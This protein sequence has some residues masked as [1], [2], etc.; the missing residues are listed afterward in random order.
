M[1]VDFDKV[2]DLNRKVWEIADSIDI[3]FGNKQELCGALNQPPHLKCEE[4]AEDLPRPIE[5]C[6]VDADRVERK[7]L[8]LEGE[9]AS[10]V[11]ERF[12]VGDDRE[13][14][15]GEQALARAEA[16]VGRLESLRHR[17]LALPRAPM[18]R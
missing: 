1:S 17:Y 2:L 14:L 7:L 10:F 11:A 15:A 16:A 18:S 4:I 3:I 12:D 5:T 6:A 9:F 13:R 8:L